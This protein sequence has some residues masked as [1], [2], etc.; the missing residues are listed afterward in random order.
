MCVH[1][2]TLC[3]VGLQTSSKILKVYPSHIDVNKTL[4]VT[5]AHFRYF[6][7]F[8]PAYFRHFWTYFEHFRRAFG[9]FYILFF[10]FFLFEKVGWGGVQSNFH[11]KPNIG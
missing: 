1:L 10:L 4:K 5:P 3:R 7:F 2:A 6:D 11:V 8:F 9:H